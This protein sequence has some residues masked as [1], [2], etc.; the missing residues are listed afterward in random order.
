M[1]FPA[2]RRIVA[3][4]EAVLETGGSVE[5]RA[6]QVMAR[7]SIYGLPPSSGRK[8]EPLPA[9]QR[10]AAMT[11][12]APTD[13]LFQTADNAEAF[14]ALRL[15]DDIRTPVGSRLPPELCPIDEFERT[16]NPATLHRIGAA[17]VT[18]AETG[19]LYRAIK[20][21]KAD[22]FAK[23]EPMATDVPALAL[24]FERRGDERSAR[25]EINCVGRSYAFAERRRGRPPTQQLDGR[26]VLRWTVTETAFFL[27]GQAGRDSYIRTPA[28]STP[29]AAQILA[30]ES[31]ANPAN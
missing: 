22:Y 24:T 27:L 2:F 16:A 4:L 6:R 21:W 1:A 5:N 25:L 31:R 10:F 26:A 19:D 9:A 30:V 3:D 23:R 14:C 8:S 17:L 7:P 15:V 13:T 18:R 28:T 11:S 29:F 20:A 12:L